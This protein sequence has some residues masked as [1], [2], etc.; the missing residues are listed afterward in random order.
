MSLP[1]DDNETLHALMPGTNAST[2]SNADIPLLPPTPPSSVDVPIDPQL[3][4][5]D[6]FL[7]QKPDGSLVAE[8]VYKTHL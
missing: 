4:H 8:E 1:N 7:T 2:A 6:F 3:L 5:A